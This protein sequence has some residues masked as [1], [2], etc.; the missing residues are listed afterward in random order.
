MP[1]QN[2]ETRPCQAV[3]SAARR[4]WREDALCASIAKTEVEF[5]DQ[6]VPVCRMHEA[7]YAR[8]GD[9]AERNAIELWRWVCDDAGS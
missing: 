4:G 7:T 6:L 3:P 5:C 8:W 1:P 2:V 9:T